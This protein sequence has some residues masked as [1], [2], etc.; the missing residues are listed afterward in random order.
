M[1]YKLANFG[2]FKKMAGR[3]KYCGSIVGAFDIE[4]SEYTTLCDEKF[5]FMY[6]WQFALNDITVHGRTWA[7]FVEFL[8][9]LRNELNLTIDHRLIVYVHSLTY[10]F[11]FMQHIE[12]IHFTNEKIFDFIARERH[13]I[14][15]CI[16]N[17]VFEFRDSA[18]YLEMPLERVGELVGLPKLTLDYSIVRT[19][20]TA[21]SKETVDYGERDVLI[22]TKFFLQE[23][24]KYGSV[25]NIPLTQSRRV[26][27]LMA[28]NLRDLGFYGALKTQNLY[29]SDH[30][31]ETLQAL[32][33]AYCPP[34]CYAQSAY[35]DT[36][37]DDMMHD[38]ISSFYPA[39]M[40]F[41]KF[42]H[43]KFS[44]AE[45][46]PETLEDVQVRYAY[47]PFLIKFSVTMLKNIYPRF[48][49]LARNPNWI[50]H[51]V[52]YID[53]RIL[54]AESAILT[55]TDI[56]LKNFMQYYTYDKIDIL[57]IW[58]AKRY[59]WLPEYVLKTV[60]QLYKEK[61]DA[62][63]HIKHI[64][65]N[66]KREPTLKEYAEYERIK[67]KVDRISGIFVQKPLKFTYDIDPVSHDI[68]RSEEE[69]YIKSENDFFVNYAWGVWLLAYARDI[70]TKIFAAANLENRNGRYINNDN[71]MYS[72]TDSV[73]YFV[74]TILAISIISEYNRKVNKK[75]KEFCTRNP[76][77]AYFY[78]LID[79]GKFE[80]EHY[81]KFKVCQLKRYAYQT[82]NDDFV[83]VVAGLARD[84]SHF[85]QF[86]TIEEK[87]AAFHNEMKIDEDHSNIKKRE[88]KHK[89]IEC[90]VVDCQL[91]IS[92]VVVDDC[93][94]ITK[95][96]FNC[97]G[98]S[99]EVTP[100]L[101]KKATT[102]TS[103]K[104]RKK[105]R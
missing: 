28:D 4:T 25:G 18:A 64:Q 9:S 35:N 93:V 62:K 44:R 3:S 41:E 94:L 6:M 23:S 11:T 20:E 99:Y 77:F 53:N 67:S 34:F 10:E 30:D 50:L 85:E 59:V 66:L 84:N 17:D 90:D 49:Y 14:I 102:R 48:A 46:I 74:S 31:L 57:E 32:M 104:N 79:M 5:A 96:S 56:D 19:H 51:N 86:K 1:Y 36:V 15:K 82:D 65:K 78:D 91:N 88:Y 60:V 38:D 100:E 70:M 80:H 2:K 71:I 13:D 92:R 27:R 12:G 97:N 98:L 43:G 22:L 58:T 61:C 52:N 21:L 63:K 101:L 8:E 87:F 26:K 24:K 33:S 39:I 68:R 103:L 76:S 7:E 72:D 47:K 42:P 40:C 16:V 75:L 69:V 73:Y 89:H 29:E 55:M 83:T 45:V 105:L 81:K 54:S 95:N 37:Q